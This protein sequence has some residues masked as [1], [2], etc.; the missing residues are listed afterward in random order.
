M[1]GAALISVSLTKQ[2]VSGDS[3]CEKGG[4]FEHQT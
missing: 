4:H 2:S 1:N 3:I